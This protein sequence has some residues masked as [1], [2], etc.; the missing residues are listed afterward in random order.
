[1]LCV[2]I[3]ACTLLALRS[4]TLAYYLWTY[5]GDRDNQFQDL[6][7]LLYA[8]PSSPQLLIL[9]KLLPGESSDILHAKLV[10]MSIFK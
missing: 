3:A 5:G 9:A 8:V 2:M 1:M 7:W 4:R 10:R 6:G